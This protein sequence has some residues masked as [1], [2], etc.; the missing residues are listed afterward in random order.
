M[1]TRVGE[2]IGRDKIIVDP[3]PNILCPEAKNLEKLFT[4]RNI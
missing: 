1:F 4:N 2:Y 3:D